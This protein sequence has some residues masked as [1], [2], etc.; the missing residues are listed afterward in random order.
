MY[1]EVE[2]ALPPRVNW[3]SRNYTHLMEQPTLC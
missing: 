3:V 1:R 2:S